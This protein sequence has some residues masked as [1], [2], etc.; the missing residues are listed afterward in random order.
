[1]LLGTRNKTR[2]SK[3]LSPPVAPSFNIPCW[4]KLM[5]Q[6]NKKDAVC[7]LLP[8]APKSSAQKLLLTH[9]F[10]LQQQTE[11][12]RHHLGLGGRFNNV[13][14]PDPESFPKSQ[15]QSAGSLRVI[16]G[17]QA[18]SIE[19]E[20]FV[21]IDWLHRILLLLICLRENYIIYVA[22]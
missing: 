1:M 15:A 11:T 18:G 7:R 13:D 16:W 20:I 14:K 5:R 10:T 4:K 9:L 8:L 3:F 6:A 19:A 22:Y 21:V 2:L 17:L 12:P